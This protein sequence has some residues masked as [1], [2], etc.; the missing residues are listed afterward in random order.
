[1][2]TLT[3]AATELANHFHAFLVIVHHI[4]LADDKRLRDHTSLN[5][6][7]DASIL[8]K[9]KQGELATVLTLQELKD[10]A[11]NSPPT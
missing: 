6:A 1:M 11:S 9:R 10:T 2:V 5:A 3:A 7:L 8:C 4:G